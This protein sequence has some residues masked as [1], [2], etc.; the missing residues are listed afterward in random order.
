MGIVHRDISP[1]NV[2]VT[3][4]G[5]VKLLDFGIAKAATHVV[6]TRS[7]VIKGKFAYMAHEQISSSN[8]GPQADV[9][10]VGVVLHECL[11]GRRLFKGGS[12]YETL[13]KV[14]SM[15]VTRPS[16]IETTIPDAL[17]AI[18]MKALERDR[19]RRYER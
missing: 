12:D 9:F 5:S 11:T 3:Y 13:Q 8:P 16:T 19:A 1:Q 2:F 17:D 6:Q 4:E 18:V 14:R 10:A 15:E 7:G